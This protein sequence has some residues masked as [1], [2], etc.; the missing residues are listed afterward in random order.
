M[1]VQQQEA[2]EQVHRPTFRP[3]PNLSQVF[4]SPNEVNIPLQQRR[5]QY[6]TQRFFTQK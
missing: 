2:P 6:L 1:R 3:E 5:P 4:R